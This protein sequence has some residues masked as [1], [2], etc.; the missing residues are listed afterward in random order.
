MDIVLNILQ[1]GA[2][3]AAAGIK[4]VT[5]AM[6]TFDK[7][8]GAS[9]LFSK[10]GAGFRGQSSFPGQGL[11]GAMAVG[12]VAGLVG[13]VVGAAASALANAFQSAAREAL[14]LGDYIADTAEQLRA[15]PTEILKLRQAASE[16]GMSEQKMLRGLQGLEAVRSAALGGDAKSAALFQRFGI[17]GSMLGDEKTSA[18]QIAQAIA[19]SLG[20]SGVLRGDV[21]PLTQL[22][23]RNAENQLKV[24]AAMDAAKPKLTDEDIARLDRASKGLERLHRSIVSFV[25]GVISDA[26]ELINGSGKGVT[27]NSKMGGPFWRRGGYWGGADE[28][29]VRMSSGS[30]FKFGQHVEDKAAADRTAAMTTPEAI[31]NLKTTTGSP[32]AITADAL[33][34]IGIYRGG[35]NPQLAALQR[36]VILQQAALRELRRLNSVMDK[37]TSDDSG[38]APV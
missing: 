17:S 12:G 15:T 3:S 18:I 37:A 32:A 5:D 26:Y 8:T 7:R 30:L 29:G 35:Q 10:L 19:K 34:R 22:L 28:N 2:S 27:D 14:Q 23:G 16:A 4:Q 38:F 6:N 33:A 21:A 31:K 36:Q 13:G 11:A 20:S 24:L 25:G 9:G 1:K